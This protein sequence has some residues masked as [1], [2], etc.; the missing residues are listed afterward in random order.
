MIRLIHLIG[1]DYLID[2]AIIEAIIWQAEIIDSS[3]A[4]DVRKVLDRAVVE[5][6]NLSR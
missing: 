6:D 4:A 1:P 5:Q 3:F 2:V